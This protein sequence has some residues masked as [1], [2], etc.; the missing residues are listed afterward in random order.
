MITIYTVAYNEDAKLQFMIDHYRS[1]FPDCHIVLYDNEST[2][3]TASIAKKNNCEIIVHNTNGK[4]ND[5]LL[6]NLKNNCWKQANTNWVLVCDPDELLNINEA[7]LKSEELLGVTII[8]P[9]AYNMVPMKDEPLDLYSIKHGVRSPA[10]D[11][12][13]LFNK[14]QIVDINYNH[15]CHV[16]RPQGNITYS[17]NTYFLYHFHFV[18]LDFVF[19]RYQMT[20]KRFSDINLQNGWGIHCFKTKEELSQI[21]ENLRT[22]AIRIIE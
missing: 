2:D 16:A 15:G 20:V 4:H 9:E 18:N 1:R 13:F 8:K 7:Q 19:D 22:N 21:F 10:H 17:K 11:K 12:C 3:N 5:E 14:N 6:M